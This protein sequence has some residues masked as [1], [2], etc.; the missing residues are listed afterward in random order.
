MTIRSSRSGL[1]RY[2]QNAYVRPT[3]SSVNSAARCLSGESSP[4]AISVDHDPEV[5]EQEDRPQV[6]EPAGSDCQSVEER[7]D[8]AVV[9]E[10]DPHVREDQRRWQ[11]ERAGRRRLLR[12]LALVTREHEGLDEA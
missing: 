9:D 11:V 4:N 8:L 2:C 3:S 10:H 12:V 6:V 1:Y 7:Q 5:F